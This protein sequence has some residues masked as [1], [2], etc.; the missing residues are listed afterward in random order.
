MRSSI[1]VPTGNRSGDCANDAYV[2]QDI[3]PP[4][5]WDTKYEVDTVTLE[6]SPVEP[7]LKS[8]PGRTLIVTHDGTRAT[9]SS[10]TDVSDAFRGKKVAGDWTLRLTGCA[11]PPPALIITVNASCSK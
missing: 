3:I 6:G 11:N 4:T 7:A 1:S 8:F 10:A 5:N 9:F 2:V